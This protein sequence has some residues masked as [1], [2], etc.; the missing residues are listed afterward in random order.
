MVLLIQVVTW[1]GFNVSLVNLPLVIKKTCEY[2]IKYGDGSISQGDLSLKTLTLDFT[3]GSSISFPKTVIGFG[4]NNT[5]SFEGK[6]S[7][8]VG[9]GNGPV[10]LIN[11]LGS[12]IG[13]AAIVSGHGVVST[14]L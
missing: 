11:Q 1:F 3:S 2:T 8:L 14:P 9:L 10:S 12:S 13:E 4:H 6:S 5:L 7:G